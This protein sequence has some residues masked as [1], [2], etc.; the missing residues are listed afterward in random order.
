MTQQSHWVGE[1]AQVQSSPCL[2][3][4][5]AL[6]PKSAA[7]PGYGC[8][9]HLLRK[10]SLLPVSLLPCDPRRQEGAA[11]GTFCLDKAIGRPWPNAGPVSNGRRIPI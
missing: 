1:R 3:Y 8:Q 5:M 2:G 7:S 10:Q 4:K 6:E 11:W 9:S